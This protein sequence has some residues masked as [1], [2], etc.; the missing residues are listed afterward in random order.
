MELPLRPE[1]RRYGEELPESGPPRDGESA[2][3]AGPSGHM[4]S[5]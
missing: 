5:D 3:E 4:T 1:D 2:T